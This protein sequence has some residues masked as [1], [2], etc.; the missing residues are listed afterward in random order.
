MRTPRYEVRQHSGVAKTPTGATELAR[1]VRDMNADAWADF[2]EVLRNWLDK[3]HPQVVMEVGGGRAPFFSPSEFSDLGVARYIINDISPAELAL[4]PA[5]YD[6]ACFDI[7][8]GPSSTS[9]I[10]EGCD[11]IFS[12]M[13]MEHIRDPRAAWSSILRLLTDGGTVLAFM[14]VLFSPPFVINKVIPDAI[15]SRILIRRDP[16]RHANDSPKF[17]AYYRWCRA[18]SRYMSAR[19][20]PLGYSSVEVVPFYRHGYFERL[21]VLRETDRILSRFARRHDLTN[22]ASYAYV[23]ASK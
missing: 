11:F 8:S 21:P 14:P 18:S 22:L 15:G 1:L 6:K 2:P 19:L 12:K 13:V 20:I 9:S 10:L 23:I 17:P 16:R 7:Q 3:A 4:A 5:G